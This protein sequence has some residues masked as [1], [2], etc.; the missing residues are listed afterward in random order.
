M[1]GILLVIICYFIGSIPFSY[2]F[3]RIFTHVDVRSKGSGNV[4]ATNVFRTVGIKVAVLALAGD[5]LKGVL[6]A[7]IGTSF[8][9]GWLLVFCCMA[10]VIGH[11]YPIFLKFKGGKAVATAGGIVLF[12]M[13]KIGLTL[14]LLFICIVYVSR[15]VSLG[16][17][18]IAT[19][20][21]ITAMLAAQPPEYVILSWLLAGLVVY[22]HRENIVRLRNGT[23]SRLRDPA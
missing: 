16:S 7:W 6:A 9:S 4:G 12:L 20:L 15:Y 22:R 19:F 21:P 14:L 2:I 13:P 18:T 1:K 8:A 3:P 10:A 17:V 11:C 23:E 5:L